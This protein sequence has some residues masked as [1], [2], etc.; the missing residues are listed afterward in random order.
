MEAVSAVKMRKAQE[1]ALAMRSYARAAL[2]I[3]RALSGSV[4]V[5]DHP[6]T[7]ER[8]VGK[9]GILV[10]TSDK[11]L[12]GSLNSAV[13]KEVANYIHGQEL[14]SGDVVF[15]CLG[16]RGFEYA[17]AREYEVVHHH[18]NISDGIDIE[19]FREITRQALELFL[20]GT[21]RELRVAYTDFKSTFEQHAAMHKI[22]PL[23]QKM[24]EHIVAEIP[25][26][27]G[28]FSRPLTSETDAPA[29]TIEPEPA[30]VIA[31]LMPMLVNI[32]IFNKLLESKASEHSARMIAMKS[33]TD[34][35]KEVA[36]SLTRKFNKAR[37]AAITR[38]VSEITS[39]IEAMK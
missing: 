20:D 28:K 7:E 13:L 16:K 10:I 23:S 2:R 26:E 14:E 22:L 38:E 25:P 27:K 21:I 15:F 39:G 8:A 12:A 9:V 18:T 35:A 36:T 6:L 19:E 17:Q 5:R 11:G 31:I 32:A 24:I 3:L 4:D 34:K 37:Q 33:A 1:R 29:Y 30:D